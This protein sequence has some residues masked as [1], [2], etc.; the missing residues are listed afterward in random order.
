MRVHSFGDDE[1]VQEII[2]PAIQDYMSVDYN[3][4][5]SYSVPKEILSPK[6]APVNV[7]H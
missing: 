5:N 4:P 2:S 3:L 7:V 1:S 6:P